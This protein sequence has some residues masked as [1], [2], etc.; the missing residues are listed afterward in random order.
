M[1]NYLIVSVEQLKCFARNKQ[2]NFF[3]RLNYGLL[4]RKA[5][6]YDST[7]NKF[8]VWNLIDGTR[9]TLTE[10]ELYKKSNIGKAIEKKAFYFED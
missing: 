1:K 2:E 5:I 8:Y 10:R 3:I 4:S 6:K 7:R 9:Q